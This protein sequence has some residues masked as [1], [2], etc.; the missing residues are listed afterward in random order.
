MIPESA[1]KRY[2]KGVWYQTALLALL[3]STNICF[4]AR[5]LKFQSGIAIAVKEAGEEVQVQEKI[6]FRGELYLAACGTVIK[7]HQDKFAVRIAKMNKRHPL[8]VGSSFTLRPFG[9]QTASSASEATVERPGSGDTEFGI[10]LGANAGLTYFYGMG[11]LEY[12]GLSPR[13]SIGLQ[14]LFFYQ[15]GADA[16][17]VGFGGFLTAGLDFGGQ[18]AEGF[19]FLMGAGAYFL[20]LTLS[21]TSE[22]VF[23]PTGLG[24]LTYQYR[25]SGSGFTLGARAGAQLVLGSGTVVSSNFGGVL[26]LASLHAGF[27]F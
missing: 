19:G 17:A 18:P 15:P 24:Q 9:R 3:F 25:F 6:C 21:T 27:V 20:T 23:L 22:S 5:L 10:S 13:W 16:S 11:H 4:A 8:E 14:P 26:P 2:N 7:L 12:Y 1:L